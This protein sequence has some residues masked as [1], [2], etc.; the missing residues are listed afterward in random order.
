MSRFKD[1]EL[2]RVWQFP[3]KNE[4]HIYI[5][6]FT[7]T[8]LFQKYISCI[9]LTVEKRLKQGRHISSVIPLWPLLS[10][11]YIYVFSDVD[12]KR[13]KRRKG[14]SFLMLTKKDLKQ[15]RRRR[16]AQKRHYYMYNMFL[17]K[18]RF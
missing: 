2:K 16:E 18:Q 15:T 12:K 8:L 4:K 13:Y 5:H 11:F 1:K 17:K 6:S 9:C 3:G 7:K 14:M 10:V